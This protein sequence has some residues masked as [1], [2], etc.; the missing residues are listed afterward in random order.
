MEWKKQ[1]ENRAFTKT[2]TIMTKSKINRSLTWDWFLFIHGTLRT[3]ILTNLLWQK[4]H[5]IKKFRIATGTIWWLIRRFN[6][7]DVL[8]KGVIIIIISKVRASTDERI[9]DKRARM[10]ESRLPFFDW[11]FD[12]Q[13]PSLLL[14]ASSLY[15]SFPLHTSYYLR[16]P[17]CPIQHNM[18]PFLQKSTLPHI[19]VRV[20]VTDIAHNRPCVGQ[21]N[22]HRKFWSRKRRRKMK[23]MA[24]MI[25]ICFKKKLKS[26]FQ[27]RAW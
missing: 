20:F 14:W 7:F 18:R 16:F 23:F 22:G 2:K 6:T 12:P 3:S 1:I 15:N 21:R 26:L 5:L 13:E 25:I 24:R 8:L 10:G 19:A 9:A 27:R 4:L 11:L 17:I